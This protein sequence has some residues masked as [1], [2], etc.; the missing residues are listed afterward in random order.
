[1]VEAAGHE[2]V[3][4]CAARV[5]RAGLNLVIMS[6]GAPADDGVRSELEAA[7]RSGGGTVS[8]PSGAVGGFD[9]LTSARALADLESVV[10]RTVKK[11]EAFR[12]VP[13]VIERRLLPAEIIAPIVL[14]RGS[15]AA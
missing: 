12:S 3:R 15:A 11:P 5:A 7:A 6:V 9:V 8:I 2:A 13:Y 4:S 14:Y 1:V 10:H